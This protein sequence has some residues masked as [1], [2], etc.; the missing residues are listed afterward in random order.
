MILA[1]DLNAEPDSRVMREFAKR[2]TIAGVTSHMD[3]SAPMP[4]TFP[5]DEPTKWIDYVLFRP[6]DRWE[7]AEVHVLDER[8]ASDHRPLLSILRGLEQEQ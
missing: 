5:S 6:A 2:W 1:G 8:V 3:D 4:L 7:V